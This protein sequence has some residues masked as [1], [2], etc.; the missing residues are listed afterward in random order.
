M[1]HDQQ[2]GLVVVSEWNNSKSVL[3]VLF[4]FHDEDSWGNPASSSSLHL[5]LFPLKSHSNNKQ[6]EDEE[7]AG[8]AINA[9][10]MANNQQEKVYKNI[11]NYRFRRTL[12]STR[13]DPLIQI[14]LKIGLLWSRKLATLSS[15]LFHYVAVVHET[16][17]SV[18][19]MAYYYYYSSS[20]SPSPSPDSLL[21]PLSFVGR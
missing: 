15:P 2:R 13:F 10:W 20:S 18:H 6:E 1:L 19:E 16:L 8:S 7:E 21:S 12:F 3:I 17:L 11:L 5:L 14:E 4:L 9:I